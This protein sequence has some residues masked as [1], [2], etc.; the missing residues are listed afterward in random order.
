PLALTFGCYYLIKVK[1]LSPLN[2]IL[3]LFV[4]AF[5]LGALGW[6]V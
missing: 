4:V 2:V 3:I 6:M 1:K 5:V